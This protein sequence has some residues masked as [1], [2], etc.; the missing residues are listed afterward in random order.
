MG[1][2]IGITV[3][4]AIVLFNAGGYAETIVLKSGKTVDGKITKRGFDY[5]EV[6]MQG[7][8]VTFYDKDVQSIDGKA[9]LDLNFTSDDPNVL[10]SFWNAAIEDDANNSNAYNELG[11]AYAKL[12][13]YQ[14]AIEC[15]QKAVEINPLFADAC[16]N[17]G[18]TYV[19]LQDYAKAV[20]FLEKAVGIEPENPKMAAAY[21]SLGSNQL[22]AQNFEAAIP[23]FE[24]AIKVDPGYA[25]AYSNLGGAYAQMGQ[26]DKGIEYLNKSVQ[27]D[28]TNINAYLNLASCYAYQG[29]NDLAIANYSK[30]IDGLKAQGNTAM[31]EKI[32]MKIEE[33]KAKEEE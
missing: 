29:K 13:N 24:K 30:A 20:P 12:N 17:I 25:A 26:M 2:V 5:I 33:L 27:I 3:F 10:I 28:G 8:T 11:L 14:K 1:R 6:D 9:T 4:V 31:A 32:A 18:L 21:N 7:V 22:K 19:S 16:A 23:F 15:F